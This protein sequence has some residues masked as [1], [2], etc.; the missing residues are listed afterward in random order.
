MEPSNF[1]RL[2]GKSMTAMRAYST[3]ESTLANGGLTAAQREQIALAVGEMNGCKACLASHAA[4]A[5]HAGLSAEDIRLARRATATD[6][7]A[8]A[9][10]GFTLA[11]VLQR[12][13][14]KMQELKALHGAGFSDADIVE[15]VANIALNIFTN[16][17]NLISNT[18]ANFPAPAPAFELAGAAEKFAGKEL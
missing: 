11:V 3:V 16:Y 2:L 18:E 6:P 15:I 5:H 7:A 9:M 1:L 8:K 13:E 12:G 17:L 10:L 14:V 4:A